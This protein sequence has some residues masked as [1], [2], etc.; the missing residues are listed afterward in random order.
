MYLATRIA[1]TISCVETP[2]FCAIFVYICV[3][4]SDPRAAATAMPAWS[5]Y[6]FGTD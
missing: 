6:F 4:M 1:S 3:Q 5:L 2:L